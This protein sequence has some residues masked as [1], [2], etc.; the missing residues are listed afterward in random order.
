MKKGGR[1][2]GETLISADCQLSQS[3]K[4]KKKEGK[5]EGEGPHIF[6]SNYRTLPLGKQRSR[7]EEEGKKEGGRKKPNVP[8]ETWMNSSRKEGEKRKGKSRTSAH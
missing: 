3:P 6:P 1:R 2:G 8:C 4:K 5:R 7:K